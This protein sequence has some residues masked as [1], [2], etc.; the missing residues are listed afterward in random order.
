[1]TTSS[2]G[3]RWNG[4]TA[5]FVLDGAMNRD[6]F[7]AYVDKVLA[8]TLS[9]GD[10]VFIDNL[11]AHKSATARKLIEAEGATLI[12]L[13]PYSPALNPIELA[14]AKLKALLRKAAERTVAGLW[15]K[16]GEILSACTP[17]E[18]ANHLRHD[19]YASI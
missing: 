18:C 8:P 19:E 1:M 3:L 5:P 4:I 12:F 15:D 14:L 2:A 7:E 11:P 13:P 16:I 6:A 10:M 9:E 17:Q